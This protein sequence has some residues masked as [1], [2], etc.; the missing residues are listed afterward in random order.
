V[1]DGLYSCQDPWLEA[2][3]MPLIYT[4]PTCKS[5]LEVHVGLVGQ[6]VTCSRC[7]GQFKVPAPQVFPAEGDTD[8]GSRRGRWTRREYRETM[9]DPEEADRDPRERG[10]LTLVV[11]IMVTVLIGGLGL[12]AILLLIVVYFLGELPF[13]DL[14]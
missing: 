13:D 2:V 9:M 1:L 5:D 10:G 7:Q 14:P 4:C 6:I 11:F 12:L 8:T 3:L